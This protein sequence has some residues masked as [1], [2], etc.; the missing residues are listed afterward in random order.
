MLL[1]VGQLVVT[2]VGSLAALLAGLL[3]PGVTTLA[4]LVTLGA[5][6]LLTLTVSVIALLALAASGPLLVQ[7][8]VWPL[9]E[10]LQPVPVPEMKLRPVGK[11]SVMVIVPVVLALPAF[12]TF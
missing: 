5:A 7:V 3:S 12:E 8:T 11:V 6:A 9:A 1:T 2:V 4:V 10:Q